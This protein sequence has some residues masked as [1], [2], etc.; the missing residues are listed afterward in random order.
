MGF[1]TLTL[2]S[3]GNAIH[4]NADQIV[5]FEK[6]DPHDWDERH[7]SHTNVQLSTGNGFKV[8][9]TVAEIFTEITRS[10]S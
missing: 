9:E 10:K 7:T 1:I 3:S 6:G 5:F 2:L 8:Y 4:I